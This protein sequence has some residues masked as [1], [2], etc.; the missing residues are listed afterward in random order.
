LYVVP[1]EV[2]VTEG[3]WDPRT[4]GAR[5]HGHLRASDADR[6]R[7]IDTLKA[8]FAQGR[9]TKDELAARTGQA[10]AAR[11]YGELTTATAGLPVRAS[12]TQPRTRPARARPQK[13]IDRATVAWLICM[14]LLPA[15][16]GAA[17]VTYYAGFLVLF[18]A[19]FIGVTVTARL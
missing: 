14:L 15:T 18:L 10:L 13:R 5:G 12:E 2:P 16:L 17:F 4:A 1:R 7:A 8:A 6:E 19:A 3:P 9:M 11:T